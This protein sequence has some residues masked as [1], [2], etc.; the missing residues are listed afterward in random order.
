M[1]KG[2]FILG[3]MVGA[4]AAVLLSPVNGS[5]ARRNLAKKFNEL[6]IKIIQLK[7]AIK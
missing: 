6:K 4:V 5:E 3:A 2:K 7:T 1:K